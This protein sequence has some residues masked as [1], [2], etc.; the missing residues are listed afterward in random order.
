MNLKACKEQKKAWQ[1]HKPGTLHQKS[2]AKHA[3][4]R[5]LD[6]IAELNANPKPQPR[7]HRTREGSPCPSPRKSSEAYDRG[8]NKWNRAPLNYFFQG[9]IRLQIRDSIEFNMDALEQ[10]LGQVCRYTPEWWWFRNF[11]G[12]LPPGLQIP[13]LPGLLSNREKKV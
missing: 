9:S 2:Y 10:T 8:L 7:S 6:Y 13:M 11:E 1:K 12:I 4:H 5:R 3:R